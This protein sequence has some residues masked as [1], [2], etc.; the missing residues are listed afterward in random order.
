[1]LYTIGYWH[2]TVRPTSNERCSYRRFSSASILLRLPVGKI[3]RRVT[4][5]GVAADASESSVPNDVLAKFRKSC[6][7]YCTAG[8]V[9]GLGSYDAWTPF[10]SSLSLVSC[11]GDRHPSNIM[12]TPDGRLF[13][14]DFG[15]ILGDYV[16]FGNIFPRETTSI[17]LVEPFLYVINNRKQENTNEYRD[18]I[19][20]C[21]QTFRLLREHATSIFGLLYLTIYA[22]LPLLNNISHLNYLRQSL[23]LIGEKPFE[24]KRAVQAYKRK[25][26]SAQNDTRRFL[27]WIAHAFVHKPQRWVSTSSLASLLSNQWIKKC[28]FVDFSREKLVSK[29]HSCH[30]FRFTTQR[31]AL[32]ISFVHSKSPGKISKKEHARKGPMMG[33]N[34]EAMYTHAVNFSFFRIMSSVHGG[35]HQHSRS[36]ILAIYTNERNRERDSLRVIHQSR[37]ICNWPCL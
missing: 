23:F 33:L 21:L 3:N 28:T 36:H 12:L 5:G 31:K 11:L 18:F 10:H 14:V 22:R 37:K 25:I 4:N 26:E 34:I 27:D 29:G 19:Q 20:L 7:A 32:F 8:F 13:H 17:V 24:T 16:K 30:S 1:M 15:H 6:A 9:I 35:F 2:R